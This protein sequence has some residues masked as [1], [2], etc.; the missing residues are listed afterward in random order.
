MF[1]W[2]ISPSFK[3]SKEIDDEDDTTRTIRRRRRTED[4][5]DDEVDAYRLGNLWGWHHKAEKRVLVG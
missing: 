2:V 4:E 3:T 5:H 1:G